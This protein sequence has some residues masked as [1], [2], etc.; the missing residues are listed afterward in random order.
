MPN[1]DFQELRGHF[2]GND[3]FMTH[4]HQII[5]VRQGNRKTPNWVKDDAKIQQ[6]LLQSFP[7]MATDSKQRE[8]A[9]RWV[10]AFYL[11][12]RAGMTQSNVAEEMGITV[13]TAVNIITRIKAAAKGFR[14]DKP[15]V[16]R[17]LRPRGRPKKHE[18]SQTSLGSRKS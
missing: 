4:G 18:V 2:D 16:K 3:T 14:T 6:I 1:P 9:G 7:K 13:K 10:R 5:K 12:F 11:Y 15:N 17:G 8:R